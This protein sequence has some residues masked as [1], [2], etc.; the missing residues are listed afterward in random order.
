MNR[1]LFTVIGTLILLATGI[2]TIIAVQ[3]LITK[4]KIGLAIRA[5]A[6]DSETARIM[7]INFHQIVLITFM[8][9]SA[10][11][12]LAGLMNGLYYNEVNFGMGLL[13]GVIGFSAAVVG[14]LGNFYG[15]IVGGFLFAGL[16]TVGAVM[17]PAI[18]PSVPSAY[19]DVFAFTVI[20]IIM[21]L[22]PTGLI[23]EKSSERV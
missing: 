21:G 7:G 23:S 15:A 22:K 14:G 19:K 4:S 9:G 3:R 6:Q 2:I 11:A 18:L 12:A 8:L 1:L 10:L 17:L 5:V 13:L 20:I 16:Q